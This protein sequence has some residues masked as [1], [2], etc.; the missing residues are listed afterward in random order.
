MT[1]DIN[2][3]DQVEYDAE[4]EAA[5][6]AY[7]DALLAEFYQSDEG[8]SL[9]EAY[10][11]A[12]VGFWAAQLIYYGYVYDGITLPRMRVMD[13]KQIVTGLFPRK[14]SLSSA[15]EA[16][17]AIPELIAFWQFL[18]RAYQLSNADKIVK[19]LQQIE[20][21]FKEMMMDPANFGMAKSLFMLAQSSGYDMTDEE[22]AQR[23]IMA[24]NSGQL[25]QA[26]GGLPMPSLGGFVD[27]SDRQRGSTKRGSRQSKKKKT[28]KIAKA[29]RKKNRKKRK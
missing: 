6:E 28:R 15:E 21:E 25:G 2:Q 16:D 26:P 7:Q 14:V 20:P 17:D 1:F 29:S 24:Y 5:L 18:K 11:N 12:D 4:G 3:L 19:F 8:K 22:D 10:P 27:S 23:F 9:A 13:V